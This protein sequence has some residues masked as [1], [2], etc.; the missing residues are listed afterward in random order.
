MS[1]REHDCFVLTAAC[2]T[3]GSRRGD[4]GTIVHVHGASVAYEVEFM[5]LSG[6]TIVDAAALRPAGERDLNHLRE[7][8]RA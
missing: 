1:L 2:L 7:F 6:N 3:S 4:V 5:T 8:Q